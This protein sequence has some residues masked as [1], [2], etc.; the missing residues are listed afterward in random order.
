[1]K[2]ALN[3]K[4]N[5]LLSQELPEIFSLLKDL[6]PAPNTETLK[7]RDRKWRSEVKREEVCYPPSTEVG[8]V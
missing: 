5:V 6:G 8:V 2:A 3:F 7:Q 4:D 1:M